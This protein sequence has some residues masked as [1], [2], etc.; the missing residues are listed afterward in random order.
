MP[1]PSAMVLA[2]GC[3]CVPLLAHSTIAPQSQ[4]LA[5]QPV[6]ELR[7]GAQSLLARPWDIVQ[8]P[9]GS[10]WVVDFSDRNIK[11]YADDGRRV[12]TVGSAG[13][14]PGQF[15]AVLSVLEM[16]D[17]V[18]AYDILDS[19]L[20][21]LDSLGSELWRTSLVEDRRA[22]QPIALRYLG[23]DRLLAVHQAGDDGEGLLEVMDFRGSVRTTFMPLAEWHATSPE[24]R[25]IERIMAD[26]FDGC[27]FAAST[28]SDSVRVFDYSGRQ[29]AAGVWDPSAPWP[30]VDDPR[31]VPPGRPHVL[32]IVALPGCRALVQVKSFENE[33]GSPVSWYPLGGGELGMF[34][35]TAP[36][37]IRR[38]ATTRLTDAGLL[39]RD[40]DG[41]ALVL[42][43]PHDA[44][45]SFVL[46]RVVEDR[47]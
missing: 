45:E 36:G 22:R 5:I 10:F 25:G 18:G 19:Q 23:P 29:R 28:Y 14:G 24:V 8:R 31:S 15:G 16:G 3:L 43:T 6:A 46:F 47:R 35:P 33:D 2:L 32:G 42:G 13:R 20:V 37:L 26:A 9:D 11:V 1:R 44:Y 41:N 34:S 38:T 27:I 7:D 30:K 12:A 21:A 39:G 40:H 4:T 17:G